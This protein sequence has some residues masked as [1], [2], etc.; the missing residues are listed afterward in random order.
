M[1]NFEDVLVNLVSEEVDRVF[2][3]DP[4]DPAH[5]TIVADATEKI[6]DHVRDYIHAR[7][8]DNN[9]RATLGAA[10]QPLPGRPRRDRV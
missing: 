8:L 7:D 4:A 6:I 1:S 5:D 2:Q 3:A 9:V 10:P